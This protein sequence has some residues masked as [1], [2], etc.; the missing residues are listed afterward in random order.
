MHEVGMLLSVGILHLFP[1]LCTT[2][3]DNS[4]Y[5]N[6]GG[7]RGRGGGSERGNAVLLFE[8]LLEVGMSFVTETKNSARPDCSSFR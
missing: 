1:Q 3:N 2:F 4:C 6:G 5:L 7:G 8:E